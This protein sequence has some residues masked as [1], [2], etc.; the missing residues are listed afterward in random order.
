MKIKANVNMAGVGVS[1][2]QGQ[3][4]E[5]DDAEADR[6]IAAG[7][8]SAVDP[9]YKP[10]PQAKPEPVKLDALPSRPVENVETVK[11]VPA[12]IATPGAGASEQRPD[13][14]PNGPTS[15]LTTAAPTAVDVIKKGSK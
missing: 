15:A 5:M 7:H 14:S 8:V 1:Y 6:L 12:K 11:L 10:K 3:E 9:N 13:Q 4:Y 2:T